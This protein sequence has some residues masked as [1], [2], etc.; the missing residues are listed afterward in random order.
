LKTALYRAALI[1]A[2]HIL[3]GSVC[4][5]EPAFSALKALFFWKLLNK[6]GFGP[7]K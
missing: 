1:C 7:R 5:T 6:I 4:V 2:T 3:T